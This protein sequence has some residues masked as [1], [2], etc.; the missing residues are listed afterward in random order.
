MFTR[1]DAKH[2]ERL[3]V[4]EVKWFVIGAIEGD[5]N[6]DASGPCINSALNLCWFSAYNWRYYE[7]KPPTAV[8]TRAIASTEIGSKRSA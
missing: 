3:N 6:V 5:L 8:S 4:M 1:R 2:F 7:K